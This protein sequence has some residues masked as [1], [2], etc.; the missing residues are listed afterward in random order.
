[1]FPPV[2]FSSMQAD[3]CVGV[4]DLHVLLHVLHNL[5]AHEQC[6]LPGLSRTKVLPGTTE[7][8]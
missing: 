8:P 4:G 7:K 3:G 5:S 1:M 2:R 6:N